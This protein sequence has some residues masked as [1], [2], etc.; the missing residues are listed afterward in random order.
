[1]SYNELHFG[2][3]LAGQSHPTF[4]LSGVF[5]IGLRLCALGKQ[6][7]PSACCARLEGLAPLGCR[8]PPSLP[9][10]HSHWVTVVTQPLPAR[11]G[12]RS[13]SILGHCGHSQR[14]ALTKL[15]PFPLLV[16][17]MGEGAGSRVTHAW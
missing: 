7:F 10:V 12:P 17:T 16:K 1:M 13:L 3:R 8:M 6:W 4:W 2:S 5:R 14:A 11:Q 15:L 9:A